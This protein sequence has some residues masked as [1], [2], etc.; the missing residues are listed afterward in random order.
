MTGVKEVALAAHRERQE[1]LEA[2]QR[3]RREGEADVERA[4]HERARQTIEASPLSGWF[5][6]VKWDEWDVM[7][8]GSKGAAAGFG[9]GSDVIVAPPDRSVHLLIEAARPEVPKSSGGAWPARP[10]T[11]YA[12]EQKWDTGTSSFNTGY[13]YWDGPE[14]KSPADIGQWIAAREAK[15]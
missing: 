9:E 10:L 4:R 6:D 13:P 2:L 3:R 15:K 14:V 11:V 7:D 8:F 12:V 1:Q 5:P